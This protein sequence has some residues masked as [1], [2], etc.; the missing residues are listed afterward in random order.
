MD[1]FAEKFHLTACLCWGAD[2]ATLS[3][4]EDHI[5]QTLSNYNVIPNP[6]TKRSIEQMVSTTA[7][8]R[9]MAR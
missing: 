9:D 5:R 2:K 6:A 7:Y 4:R 1:H 8:F 3:A